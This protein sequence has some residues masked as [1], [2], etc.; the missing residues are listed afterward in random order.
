[1]E[2]MRS[3][4]NLA[5]ITADAEENDDDM[6]FDSDEERAISDRNTQEVVAPVYKPGP[7]AG[8]D[9]EAGME[10]EPEADKEAER[11]MRDIMDGAEQDIDKVLANG[12]HVHVTEGGQKTES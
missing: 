9:D 2:E 7:V 3:P 5:A 10:M 11:E 8:D 6:L 1:M 4:A 12:Y